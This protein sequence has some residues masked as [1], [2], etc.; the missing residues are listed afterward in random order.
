[1][2]KFL[3]SVN[4]YSNSLCIWWLMTCLEKC[5]TD[6]SIISKNLYWG[7]V[8]S[9]LSAVSLHMPISVS[10]QL[11]T[12]A[13]C[14]HTEKG[15]A[16]QRWLWYAWQTLRSMLKSIS[17]RLPG[18]IMQ[19]EQTNAAPGMT[20]YWLTKGTVGKIK[21]TQTFKVIAHTQVKRLNSVL[22]FMNTL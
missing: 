8:I 6:Y 11:K 13:V 2:L 9:F 12:D 7:L 16:V 19:L 17:Q 18:I 20:I 4:Y 15:V 5:F 14:P 22:I 21:F 3:F 10:V 1:M